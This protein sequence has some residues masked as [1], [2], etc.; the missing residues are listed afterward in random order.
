MA[1]ALDEARR[2][3]RERCR[4][5]GSETVALDD[6]LD[7][8]LA[9]DAWAPQDVP[10]FAT[11]A[12]DGYAV[13]AADTAGADTTGGPVRAGAP[14]R[15]ALVSESR[16]G[17]PS[18]MALGAGQTIRIS[19]G[20]PLPE[21]ADAVVRQELTS[22]EGDRVEVAEAVAVGNDVRG[23][24][25]DVRAGTLVLRAGTPLG[26]A[27]LGVLA[28]LDVGRPDV[29]RRPRVALVGTGDELV[30]PGAPLAPGAIRDTNGPALAAAVR[31]A[32]G[33]LVA[34]VRVGDDLEATVL[35]LGAAIDAADVLITVGG[36]SVGP[37]DHIRPAL[38]RIGV[39][40]VFAGVD[41][42]P[43]RPTTFGALDDGRLVF[44]LPG[45]PVSALITFRLFVLGA[46]DALLGRERPVRSVTAIAAAALPGIRGRTAIVRCRAEPTDRGWQVTPTKAQGSH[47]LT[48]MLGVD[49][50]AVVPPDRDAIAAGEPVE[51]ELAR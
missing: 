32:G 14:V 41:L 29:V 35:A 50:L 25:E 18:S 6:A 46:L 9:G 45:N 48:S 7:R 8:V 17:T 39:P 12:M 51:V 43:G 20:A 36:V 34:R 42:R 10:P 3:V 27:E 4:R 21:G 31:H 26:P 16:A 37:H 19:T 44:A 33:E 5:L 15:L 1:V 47:V 30:D 24:G 2:L 13:R 28:S 11:S 40:E 22:A 23:A 38:A 49:A